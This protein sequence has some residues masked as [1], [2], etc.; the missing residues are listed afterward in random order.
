[1]TVYLDH[2]A[3]TPMR[4]EAI[5]ALAGALNLVGNPSSIHSHGQEARR[6]LEEA[7]E[8][9]AR[10]LDA[11]PVEVVLTSGGTESVNLGIKGLHGACV[12][13]DP[14]R[15]RIL[16][17]D[18]EHHATV[19]TVEWL[20]RRGAVVERLPI[21]ELGRIR[22]DRVAAALAVDP[23]SV[24]LLTFLAASNEVGTIQP[25][26]ELAA[27]ARAH[28]VPVHVDA[29][30]ALGHMPVPFRR[31]RDAGVHAVSVSAHKVGGPV[32]SGALVLARQAAVD[33]QIHGGG[34]QRQ[35]RSGTQDAASAV[36][37]AAAVTLAVAELDAEAV[38]V[39]RLRD[40]LV[41]S[42]LRDVPGAVLRGDPDP[43]GR[44][45]GNAH[46]TF[47]GCQGDSLLLLLDM[48]GVSVSTGSACQ[49]GVPEVSHVLLGMGVPDGEARGALRFTLGR[50]TTDADV[51]ALLA[52]L[53]D[54][55]ARASRA[56]L[57]G[58]AARRLAE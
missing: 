15:T 25:V 32:G 17:P 5:A 45:P 33:P 7:R 58:R 21:D 37:F 30:A 26:E 13:A 1:M 6:V 52:A 10:A 29:V 31:W 48:A 50:T 22:V 54:A 35:V 14:R 42:V 23:G 12:A 3:T 2:A 41:E 24:S 11:D 51:D 39:A 38:R 16:V 34:Q 8:A 19:D 43:A 20:E 56:G 4:P 57:A 53:P 49:A 47:A 28:G 9:I 46:L 36:A 18:G 40:R 55:V 27:L 44:L